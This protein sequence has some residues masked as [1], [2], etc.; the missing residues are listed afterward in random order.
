VEIILGDPI[1]FEN[2]QQ[3]IQKILL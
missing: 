2:F 1:S 3:L